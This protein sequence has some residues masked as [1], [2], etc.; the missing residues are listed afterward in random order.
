VKP[1]LPPLK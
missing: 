1:E